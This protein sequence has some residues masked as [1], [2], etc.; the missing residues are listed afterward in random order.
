MSSYIKKGSYRIYIKLP[1][2]NYGIKLP[3]IN[4][5]NDNTFCSFLCGIIMNI[6][7]RSRYKMKKYS[8]CPTYFSFFGLFNIVRNATELPSDW[9][10]I[11]KSTY[12][13]DYKASPFT[14]SADKL[15]S[16]GIVDGKLMEIDYGDFSIYQNDSRRL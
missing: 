14:E 10:I 8:L 9:F 1:F 11:E 3:R 12:I 7:E 6:L 16:Y 15:S 13:E 2:I 5:C 4:L